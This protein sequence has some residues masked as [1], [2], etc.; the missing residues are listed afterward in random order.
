MQIASMR[1]SGAL[2]ST[3]L[4][5]LSQLDEKGK[6]RIT[7]PELCRILGTGPGRVWQNLHGL[8]DAGVIT[9]PTVKSGW[10]RKAPYS[11]PIEIAI[12]P[13]VASPPTKRWPKPTRRFSTPRDEIINPYQFHR[14]V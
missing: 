1:L 7:Q 11:V 6:A 2:L 12:A 13:S 10:G 5:L 9:S 4:I 3:F 14:F 8:V